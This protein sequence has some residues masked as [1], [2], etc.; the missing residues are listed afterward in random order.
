MKKT[1]ILALSMILLLASNLYADKSDMWDMFPKKG[2]GDKNNMW[3]MFS[4]PMEQMEEMMDKMPMMDEFQDMMPMDN[5]PMIDE[6]ADNMKS[7][8][9]IG[10]AASEMKEA[11]ISEEELIAKADKDI[12]KMDKDQDIV[13]DKYHTDLMKVMKKIPLP[14]SVK[15]DVKVYWSPYLYV[16]TMPNGAIRVN[17]GVIEK[18]NDDELL[19]VMAH[20]V[21]HLLNGDYMKSHRN[22]HNMH[23]FEKMLNMGGE[24]MGSMSS[25]VM[26]SVTS[27]MRKSRFQKHE[28]YKADEFAMKVL[29]QHGIK[30][31]AAEDA[32]E[33]LMY[34]DAPILKMHPTG[35]ERLRN[36]KD[37]YNKDASKIS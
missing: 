31:E 16:F 15:L 6:M 35:Y 36:I 8:S 25:G 21:A 20:E 37:N 22:E 13:K 23:A 28:E 30:R 9:S 27:E 32:L 1:N 14:P 2:D 18:L 12:A 10:Q 24:S 4:E 26:A 19:F 29:H 33:L 11:G 7:S 34:L 5:F 17:N 3:D